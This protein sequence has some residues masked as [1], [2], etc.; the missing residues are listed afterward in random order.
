[1]P[2]STQDLIDISVGDAIKEF[3]LDRQIRNVTPETLRWYRYRLN[4][5]VGRFAKGAGADAGVP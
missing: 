3:L 2:R 1:M 5:N 4:E